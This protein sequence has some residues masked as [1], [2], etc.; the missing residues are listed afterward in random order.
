MPH[1]RHPCFI[2]Q[3]TI[4]Q[5]TLR[6]KTEREKIPFQ[7]SHPALFDCKITNNKPNPNSHFPYPSDKYG[8]PT[9]VP[10]YQKYYFSDPNHSL[11][12]MTD[13]C[14]YRADWSH[15]YTKYLLFKI[16]FVNLQK[17]YKHNTTTSKR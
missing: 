11:I 3:N 16:I 5:R 10:H 15:F 2:Y 9:Q 4:C 8:K 14:L 1:Q 17:V 12:S 6:K 7:L 13:I